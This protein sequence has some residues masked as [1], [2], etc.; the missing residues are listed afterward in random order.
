MSL[1]CSTHDRSSVNIQ[2]PTHHY[3]KGYTLKNTFKNNLDNETL[4][5]TGR[6]GLE[7][8]ATTLS[9]VVLTGKSLAAGW[10]TTDL[11]DAARNQDLGSTVRLEG[12]TKA[13]FVEALDS[14]TGYL[15]PNK[16]K[17]EAKAKAKAKL[18]KKAAKKAAKE[19]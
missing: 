16:A 19:A 2:E 13:Y 14:A 17:D 5:S 4:A 9:L 10:H 12:T 18:A 6:A 15:A 1:N 11:G 3:L 7:V 8:A